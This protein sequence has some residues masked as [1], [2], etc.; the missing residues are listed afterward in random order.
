MFVELTLPFTVQYQSP[1][2]NYCWDKFRDPADP[3]GMTFKVKEQEGKS[4]TGLAT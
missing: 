1:T 4:L 2:D 3:K